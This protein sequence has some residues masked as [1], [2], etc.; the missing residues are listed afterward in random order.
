MSFLPYLI[1]GGTAISKT[2]LCDLSA[3]AAIILVAIAFNQLII[4][5]PIESKIII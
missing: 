4:V 3:I 1:I 5:I 2:E